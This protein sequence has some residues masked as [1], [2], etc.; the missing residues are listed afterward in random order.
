MLVRV[1][2]LHRNQHQ[3]RDPGEVHHICTGS[4]EKVFSVHI[5]QKMRMQCDQLHRKSCSS[6]LKCTVHRISVPALTVLFSAKDFFATRLELHRIYTA[7]ATCVLSGF[8]SQYRRVHIRLQCSIVDLGWCQEIS[9]YDIW[10]TH[11]ICL[12]CDMI[13]QDRPKLFTK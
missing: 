10:T 5:L 6:R 13:G 7:T 3:K 1:D 2:A 4:M 11:I 12:A 8:F 9:V